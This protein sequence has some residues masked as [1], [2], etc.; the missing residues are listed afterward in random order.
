M[1]RRNFLSIQYYTHINN[2]CRT[3]RREFYYWYPLDL[4]VSGKDLIQNHLTY[5]L[6]N[7]VAI[8][9]TP[10]RGQEKEGEVCRWPRAV[11]ANGHLLL[12]SEKVWYGFMVCGVYLK[13]NIT[14]SLSLSLSPPSDVQVHW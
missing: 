5:F 6:Y 2:H 3:L 8:W 10:E 1:S 4:R 14:I 7:H 13:I 12:N 11:R 9:P